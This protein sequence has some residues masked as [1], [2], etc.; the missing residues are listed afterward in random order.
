[1]SR[2]Q[3]ISWG[4]GIAVAAIFYVARKAFGLKGVSLS[5]GK[6]IDDE[7]DEGI[8]RAATLYSGKYFSYK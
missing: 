2:A 7:K 8:Y 1:M 5:S 4:G 6:G 3:T